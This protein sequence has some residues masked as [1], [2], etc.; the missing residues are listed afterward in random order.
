MHLGNIFSALLSWCSARSQGLGFEVRLE[1]IDER[2]RSEYA[3][4]LLDDLKWLGIDWDHDPLVQSRRNDAYTNALKQLEQVAHIYPCFCSRAELH[5]TSAPHASDGTFVYQGTCKGLSD[6]Q[7][8][9]KERVRPGSLRIEV[10]DRTICFEDKCLG[11][12]EQ[13]LASECGDFVL[14]RSDGRFAYQLAVVVDDI[15]LGVSEVVRASDLASSTPRQIWLYEL[16]GAAKCSYAHH[17]LLLAPDGKRLSKREKS[18]DMGCIRKAFAHREDVVGRLAYLA[19]LLDEPQALSAQEL[20]ELFDWK[21]VV[22]SDIVV[23]S[24]GP[25]ASIY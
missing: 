19:G 3:E 13:N 6:E 2:S 12:I 10:P 11:I 1:D 16:L 18:L 22:K 15:E 4:Q 5:A 23:D 7:I 14:R 21:Y 17:P 8:A 9:K 24:F 20:A 25:I